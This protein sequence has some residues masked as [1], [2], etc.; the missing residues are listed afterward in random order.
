MVRQTD[1]QQ[2]TGTVDMVEDAEEAGT[3]AGTAKEVSSKGTARIDMIKG[4]VE[5]AMAIEMETG[6]VEEAGIKTSTAT[7]GEAGEGIEEDTRG[8]SNI[9]DKTPNDRSRKERHLRSGGKR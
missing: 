6:M 9:N 8:S 2:G 7:V 5:E 1:L 3:G 4:K